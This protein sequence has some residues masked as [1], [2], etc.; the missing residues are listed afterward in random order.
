MKKMHIIIALMIAGAVALILSAGDDM[1]SYSTF[2]DA[3]DSSSKVKIVGTLAK[4]KEMQFD[5]AEDPNYF[6]FY[7]VDGDGRE[8]KV[9]LLSEK[10]QDFE[11]S[12]QIVVTGTAKEDHFLASDILLKC[13]SKYKDEEIYIRS[14]KV[15]G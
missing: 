10:P 5:P 7:M 15:S 14:D 8:E 3:W 9:V 4:D 13:P 12:E 6:A 1:G 2:G 11:L